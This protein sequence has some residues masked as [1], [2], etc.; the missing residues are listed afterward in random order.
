MKAVVLAA[1]VGTRMRPLTYARPKVM[2]PLA[3]RPLLEHLLLEIKKAGI[4]EFLLVVGYCAQKV[5]DYFGDGSRWGVKIDYAFQRRQSG[6][7]DALRQAEGWTQEPFLLLNGDVLVKEGDIAR[8]VAGPGMAM[9]VIEVSDPAE[10]GVVEVEGD[11]VMRIHEKSPN[12]PS[13]LA[14][15]GVYLLTRDIFPALARVPK[16]PRGEYELTDSLQAVIDEG[17]PIF[18]RR[19]DYWQDLSYPWELLAANRSLLETM[20]PQNRGEVEP[21]AVVQGPVSIGKGTVVRSCSYIQGPAIIGEGCEIGPHCYIRPATAIGDGCH[22]G[23]AVEVKNSIILRGTRVPHFNYV[24]DSVIGE[25]CNFGAGTKVAN[26]RLDKKEI[27]VEGVATGLRKLGVI[28]GDEVQTGINA[29]LNV[30]SLIGSYTYIGPGA[31]ASGHVE[32]HSRIF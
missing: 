12:P 28:V 1:G 32:P 6:T 22:I 20:E 17:C 23:N 30:G 11:R 25:G 5:Q 8:V 24:G 7:A 13:R 26:L 21:G 19:L 29:S 31:V 14:N 15:A 4:G 27:R 2:L 9:G 3:N 18:H 10:K 16:S